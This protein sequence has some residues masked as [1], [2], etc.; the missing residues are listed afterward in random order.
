MA[1]PDGFDPRASLLPDPGPSV[2]IHVM[3][4]GAA[5]AAEGEEKKEKKPLPVI[6]NDA[7]LQT[8]AKYGLAKGGIIEKKLDDTIKSEFLK[9]LKTCKK[10]TGESIILKKDCWAVSRVIRELIH[11]GISS[12]NTVH[13]AKGK[14]PSLAE[15]DASEEERMLANLEEEGEE[16]QSLE[17]KEARL[18]KDAEKVLTVSLEDP[19]TSK[20]LMRLLGNI[21]EKEVQLPPEDKSEPSAAVPPA[22][23]EAPE[24]TTEVSTSSSSVS[25][26][27][28]SGTGSSA[29]EATSLPA[30][31]SFAKRITNTFTRKSKPSSNAELNITLKAAQ[32]IISKHK[33]IN[34]HED[35][36][37]FIENRS[38]FTPSQKKIMTQFS[39][40][41]FKNNSTEKVTSKTGKSSAKVIPVD[42]S[43]TPIMN[44]APS[45]SSLL[46]KLSS[47]LT[48]RKK[49]VANAN[50]NTALNGVDKILTEHENIETYADFVKFIKEQNEYT[51]TQKNIMMEYSKKVFKLRN[52]KR[53]ANE[54]TVKPGLFSKF[55]RKSGKSSAKVTPMNSTPSNSTP[56][57][58]TPSNSV[59][60][61]QMNDNDFNIAMKAFNTIIDTH[62][63]I[64]TH[65]EVIKLVNE[66]TNLTPA[67][68]KNLIET[69]KM[70]FNILNSKYSTPI[71]T[72]ATPEEAELDMNLEPISREI[73]EGAGTGLQG[74]NAIKQ[75]R[76]ASRAA[77]QEARRQ[78]RAANRETRRQ[79]R[80][81]RRQ[82][83]Q[84][85]KTRRSANRR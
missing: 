36:I 27:T 16:E 37:K 45:K 21:S 25:E 77:N 6:F 13:I 54:T 48:R 8:L 19:E 56:S 49:P 14:L 75:A 41:L 18:K 71:E 57:N 74:R 72:P 40:E 52:N 23:V 84:Q 11:T 46:S 79:T 63:N 66:R 62:P 5:A 35:F 59:I 65:E 32:N 7:E 78:S 55:T 51:P 33:N 9:Q 10:N 58:S 17:Q 31:R 20:P 43:G 34:T 70:T 73:N 81:A 85:V 30:K 64:K 44:S 61:S 47:R 80:N 83:K 82:A 42:A 15:G 4:G 26:T 68:K 12:T 38:N 22:S 2:P 29:P 60:N 76:K 1:A 39:E 3:R 24:P 28:P 53:K 50:F 69:S 67:Q